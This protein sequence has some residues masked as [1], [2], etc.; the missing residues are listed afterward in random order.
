MQ[1][2]YFTSATSTEN[3]QLTAALTVSPTLVSPVPAEPL[4]IYTRPHQNQ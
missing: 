3:Q 4:L 2:I 1:G